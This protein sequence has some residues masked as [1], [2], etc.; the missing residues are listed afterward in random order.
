VLNVIIGAG[1][2]ALDIIKEASALIPI[3]WVQTVVGGVV[4][5]LN[6]AV[7]SWLYLSLSIIHEIRII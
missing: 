2:A 6:I 3:P 7:R 5:L 1:I 4:I